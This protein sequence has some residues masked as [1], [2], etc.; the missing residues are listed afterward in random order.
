[1]TLSPSL[2]T[3]N[4]GF[5]FLKIRPLHFEDASILNS[6]VCQTLNNLLPF[7]DWAH[8]EQSEKKQVER[9]ANSRKRYASKMEYDF[10]V[11]DDN[12]EFLAAAS[13]HP[14]KSRNENSVEIGYWVHAKY[15]NKGL[16]TLVTKILIIAAF[17][18]LKCDRVEIGCN[19]KNLGSKRVIEK[20]EFKFEGEIRNYFSKPMAEMLENNYSPER[21]YLSYAL[22]SDDLDDLPW[23][24]EIKKNIVISK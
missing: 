1:M 14:S 7:M 18:F 9:I 8:G 19:K 23:Y 3:Y 20:C 24:L 11:F 4:D 15:C 2:I 5:F 16:A 17:D 13:W 6:A 12:S 21:N 22:T 10:A